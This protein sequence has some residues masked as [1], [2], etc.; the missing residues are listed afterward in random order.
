MT[1]LRINPF[2]LAN[3]Q[4][5]GRQRNQKHSN[6]RIEVRRHDNLYDFQCTYLARRKRKT[7]TLA[8]AL[9]A[10]S[11]SKHRQNDPTFAEIIVSIDLQTV[12]FQNL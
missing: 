7:E 8:L 4:G 6:G 2:W 9:V 12:V 5:R 11:S 1:G 3:L 10:S